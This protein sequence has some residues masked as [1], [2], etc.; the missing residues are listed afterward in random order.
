MYKMMVVE[1][2]VFYRYEIRNLL[3]WETYG[4]TFIGEAMNGKC[5][6]ESF[7]TEAP[8]LLL[9][10][11]SMPEMNG[12]ELLKRIQDSY[13]QMKCIVLSSYDDFSFV[14]DAMKLGAKDYILK[15]DLKEQ[16]II[17]MLEKVKTEIE[18][19]QQAKKKSQFVAENFSV[20]SNEF[21]RNILLDKKGSEKNL[22]TLWDMMDKTGEPGNITVGVLK[23][24]D[25]TGTEYE[26]AREIVLSIISTQEFAVSIDTDT[27]AI[28]LSIGRERS[29]M[30]IFEYVTRKVSAI[31]QKLKEYGIT[32]FSIGVSDNFKSIKDIAQ[33][34]RQAQKAQEQSVYE[35]YDKVY[36]YADISRKNE[37]MNLEEITESLAEEIHEGQ[38]ERARAKLQKVIEKMYQ[39]RPERRQLQNNFFLLFHVLYKVSIEENIPLESVLGVRVISED[40]SRKFRSIQE[41][42]TALLE[43]YDNLAKKMVQRDQV[44]LNVNNRQATAIMN[45]IEKNYMKE[46][47]LEVLS[48]EL[49]LTPN[50]L[51]K[52]FK[53]S[54]GMKLTQYINQIRIDGAKKLLKNTNMKAHE[55]AETVGFSSASYF[56][57]IFKQVTGQTVSEYKDSIF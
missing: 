42:E 24:I 15:Y 17:S 13:P 30:R 34:Y 38:L 37:E 25:S 7:K 50:Y 46:L 28:L 21:L 9:T 56:S 33:L 26:T 54:T 32:G 4:F 27:L 22:Q 23:F 19:E 35:G 8:D 44:G 51:C 1:D 11:I 53:N 14:K 2:D 10:D 31:Y 57:T 43:G 36:F 16:D 3:D 5:A 52:I 40:W 29:T 41:L 55:I 20:V 18:M 49:G 6:L 48:E 12:I 39:V 45:Y 47:S